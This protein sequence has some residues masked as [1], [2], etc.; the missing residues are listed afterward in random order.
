MTAKYKLVERP[1]L[2]PSKDF[3][4][5]TTE[6]KDGFIDTGFTVIPHEPKFT[7]RVYLSVATVR[8]MA[9]VAGLLDKQSDIKEAAHRRGYDEG[10]ADGLNDNLGIAELRGVADHLSHLVDRLPAPVVP[11][12]GS[13]S[14]GATDGDDSGATEAPGQGDNSP[15]D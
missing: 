13:G 1:A 14:E 11:E 6:D 15:F 9:K 7:G 2:P 12:E 8:E 4:T 10:Y 3:I 5:W